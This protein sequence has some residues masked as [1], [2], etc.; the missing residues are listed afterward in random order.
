MFGFGVGVAFPLSRVSPERQTLT[1][2]PTAPLPP[3]AA[4]PMTTAA[5]GAGV[6]GVVGELPSFLEA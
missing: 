4:L 5:G 2:T 1:G 3:P 6:A